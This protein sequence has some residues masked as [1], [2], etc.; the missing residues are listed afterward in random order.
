MKLPKLYKTRR[1]AEEVAAGYHKE[2]T[3]VFN[4]EG[5][6]K[7]GD[8]C[9]LEVN[10]RAFEYDNDFFEYELG[11]LNH[12]PLSNSVVDCLER[13]LSLGIASKSQMELLLYERRARRAYANRLESLRRRKLLLYIQEAE[14]ANTHT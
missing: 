1:F 11:L 2:V 10:G 4:R 5:V 13:A 12:K 3:A 6:Y 14:R 9:W 8:K 7:S